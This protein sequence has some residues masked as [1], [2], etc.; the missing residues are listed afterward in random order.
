MRKD[1]K[2]ETS[3]LLSDQRLATVDLLRF[4]IHFNSSLLGFEE[5]LGF[6]LHDKKEFTIKKSQNAIDNS[7]NCCD[8]IPASQRSA[9]MPLKLA[10]T[11]VALIDALLLGGSESRQRTGLS[12]TFGMAGYFG[13]SSYIKDVYGISKG[14]RAIS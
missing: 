2:K 12:V 4:Q 5:G 3:E 7:A 9:K 11:L 13:D 8:S 10:G 6:L 14:S 1:V